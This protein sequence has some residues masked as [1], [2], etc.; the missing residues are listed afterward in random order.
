MTILLFL[1]CSEKKFL[2]LRCGSSE[3]VTQCKELIWRVNSLTIENSFLQILRKWF[4]FEVLVYLINFL[5]SFF[6]WNL[7]VNFNSW[8]IRIFC[9]HQWGLPNT[10]KN[11]C[12]ILQNVKFGPNP[13]VLLSY[14]P[15]EQFWTC[16][17]KYM[18]ILN[19][20]CE[21]TCHGVEVNI[22]I[23]FNKIA[24]YRHAK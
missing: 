17:E 2:A 14:I 13:Y 11:F 9:C 8:Q 18:L 12:F 16:R 10:I 19:G 22:C 23:S 4:R 24:H 3:F 1:D 21:N 6:Q 15:R 5:F 20:F 7:N